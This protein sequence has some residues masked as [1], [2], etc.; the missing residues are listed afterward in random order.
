MKHPFIIKML[1]FFIDAEKYT[2]RKPAKTIVA[3]P[4]GM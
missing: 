2:V 4:V 3:D 1:A